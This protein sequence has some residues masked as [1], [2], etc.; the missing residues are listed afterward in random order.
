MGGRPPKL[1]RV[2]SH[3]RKEVQQVAHPRQPRGD[4]GRGVRPL[5][6]RE[7]GGHTQRSHRW[8]RSMQRNR[9]GT[10]ITSNMQTYASTRWRTASS[11]ALISCASSR[12]GP[13]PALCARLRRSPLGWRFCF[14]RVG[15][16]FSPVL[17]V[18][19]FDLFFDFLREPRTAPSFLF[20]CASSQI[21]KKKSKSLIKANPGTHRSRTE[22]AHAEQVVA[23]LKIE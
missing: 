6:C 8:A 18:G 1:M 19:N 12:Q 9:T 13:G 16:C 11:S 22:H 5:P 7:R 14:C 10:A 2:L 17:L 21:S 20:G 23:T 4:G 3:L 15:R